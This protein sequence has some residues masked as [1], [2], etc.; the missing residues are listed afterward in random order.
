MALDSS[1]ALAA[2]SSGVACAL[3]LPLGV[4]LEEV[5]VD[6]GG[7]LEEIGAASVAVALVPAPEDVTVIR[8]IETV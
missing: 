5:G 1:D 3:P 8:K 4:P 7:M 2:F 6:G